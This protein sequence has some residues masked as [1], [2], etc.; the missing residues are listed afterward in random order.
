MLSNAFC[1]LLV[2]TAV[3]RRVGFSRLLVLWLVGGSIAMMYGA[4][5]V[6]TPWNL[7]TGSSQA[8]MA[9]A[10]AGLWLALSGVDRSKGLV[11]PVAFTIAVAFTIDIVHVHY[12]KPGHVVGVLVGLLIASLC[13]RAAQAPVGG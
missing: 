3:E 8:I 10:G 9:I 7:G 6:A 5:F 4:L 12:P 13:P 1:L 2:G 11:L